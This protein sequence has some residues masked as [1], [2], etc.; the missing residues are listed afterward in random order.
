MAE[1]TSS[2]DNRCLV[3]GLIMVLIVVTF[4]TSYSQSN[5]R[6]MKETS[7]ADS[8]VNLAQNKIEKTPEEYYQMFQCSCCGQPINTGCCEIAK[9]RK[10]YFDSLSRQELEEEEIVH[11][12]V[13][14]FDYGVLMDPSKEKEVR[15]YFK[16]TATEK[17]PKI[18]IDEDTYDFGVIRQSDGEVSTT[19]N[20]MNSGKSDLI[21]EDLDTSCMCTTASLLF[22]GKESPTFGMSAHGANPKDF[23]LNIPPG[24]SATLKITYDPNAHGKQKEKEARIKRIVYI[25][26][27]DPLDFKKQVRIELTQQK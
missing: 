10:A 2:L 25:T 22:D 24:Q 19:F 11:E 15:A 9:Q 20:I 13:R 18:S 17:D 26:S 27:N 5:F 7:V 21:I 14:K 16:S 12:M 3:F 8:R 23:S 6:I 4:A 1:K